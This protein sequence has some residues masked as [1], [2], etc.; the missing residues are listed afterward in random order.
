MSIF[1]TIQISKETKA[2]L[3]Q[4]MKPQESYDS[5][6]NRIAKEKLV[7]AGSRIVSK[8][9]ILDALSKVTEDIRSLE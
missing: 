5:V 2:L 9:S 7:V 6:V 4:L 3:L 1:T 8:D